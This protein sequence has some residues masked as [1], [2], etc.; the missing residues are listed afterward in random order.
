[1][2]DMQIFG[3]IAISALIFILGWMAGPISDRE[4]IKLITSEYERMRKDLERA[5]DALER[6]EA[7]HHQYLTTV[8]GPRTLELRKAI[9]SLESERDRY[10]DAL[11]AAATVF[12]DLR[13]GR[14]LMGEDADDTGAM[15]QV[16]EGGYQNIK[17]VLSK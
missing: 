10:R 17:K 12:D 5:C 3:W 8:I 9:A 4:Y 2:T 11:G 16:A 13:C 14:M 15:I 6:K 7:L 1:M